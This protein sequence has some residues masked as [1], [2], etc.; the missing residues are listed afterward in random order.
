MIHK[1]FL[2]LSLAHLFRIFSV[3]P[4]LTLFVH[5]YLN[6]C[7]SMQPV[8]FVQNVLLISPK[9]LF[10]TQN[11]AQISLCGPFPDLLP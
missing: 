11:P 3:A 7:D 10:I 6:L 5:L 9:K 4:Y 1:A 8:P 2:D